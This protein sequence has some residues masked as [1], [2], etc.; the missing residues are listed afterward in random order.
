MA[1]S[2]S[3]FMACA[4]GTRANPGIRIIFPA[5]GIK[6][7]SPRSHG[8]FSHRN[9]DIV[10]STEAIGL[11][12]QRLLSFGHA[13][14]QCRQSNSSDAFEVGLCRLSTVHTTGT[15]DLL[16]NGFDLILH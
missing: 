4:A 14:R 16:G 11:I 5:I 8:D 1:P 2:E 9:G 7:I 12:A 10:G 13:D 15:V 6:K 3:I